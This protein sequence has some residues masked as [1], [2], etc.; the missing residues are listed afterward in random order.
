MKKINFTT[1][2]DEFLKKTL[3]YFCLQ[4]PEDEKGN[5]LRGE[6]VQRLTDYQNMLAAEEDRRVKAIFHRTGDPTLGEYV[7]IG[8]NGRAYQIPYDL[9]VVVPESVLRVADDARV[10]QFKQGGKTSAGNVSYTTYDHRVY[11]Y[12][13]I[14]YIDPESLLIPEFKNKDKESDK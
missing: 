11:P 5:F 12:T 1:Q 10:T 3:Q 4:M 7:F 6:A 2:T 14:E 9:E 13:L 8:L